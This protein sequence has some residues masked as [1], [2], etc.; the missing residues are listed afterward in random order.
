MSLKFPFCER[1]S[2]SLRQFQLRLWWQLERRR[3]REEV[4]AQGN[5]R[6][7]WSFGDCWRSMIDDHRDSVIDG[8]KKPLVNIDTRFSLFIA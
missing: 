4:E 2:G 7:T 3:L 5:Q 8:R 6:Q 1:I